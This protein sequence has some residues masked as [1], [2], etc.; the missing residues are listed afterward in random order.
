ME[1]SLLDKIW[2]KLTVLYFDI[3]DL[4]IDKNHIKKEVDE[5]IKLIETNNIEE[6]KKT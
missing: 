5:I 2:F 6:N 3:D 1:K 4:S